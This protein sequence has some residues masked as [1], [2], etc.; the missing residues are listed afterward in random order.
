MSIRISKEDDY[1]EDDI[2]LIIDT[3]YVETK[4]VDDF[5]D[6]DSEYGEIDNV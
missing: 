6:E 5:I 2:K 3:P 1:V 4:I